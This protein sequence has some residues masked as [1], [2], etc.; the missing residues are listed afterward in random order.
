MDYSVVHNSN[1]Y[2]PRSNGFIE[3]EDNI[4]VDSPPKSLKFYFGSESTD[5]KLQ[6]DLQIKHNIPSVD[7]MDNVHDITLK[8]PQIP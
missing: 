6:N 4:N 1:C 5:F 2:S 7:A 3:F 8:G